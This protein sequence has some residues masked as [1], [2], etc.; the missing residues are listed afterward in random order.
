MK[1]LLP[2]ILI[3][4]FPYVLSGYTNPAYPELY[5]QDNPLYTITLDY[6]EFSIYTSNAATELMLNSRGLSI[7]YLV[8]DKDW[9][10][11]SGMNI[12][13]KFALGLGYKFT[14]KFKYLDYNWGLLWRPVR[15]LSI[16][17]V[18]KPQSDDYYT[19][20][21]IRP[22]RDY[23][24]LFGEIHT[25]N[26]KFDENPDY[27]TGLEI[28]PLDYL[29]VV[30]SYSDSL[31]FAG[32][33]RF[34]LNKFE[35]L[36]IGGENNHYE[37]F[38]RLSSKPFTP[39]IKRNRIYLLRLNNRIIERK[40]S[41]FDEGIPLYDLVEKINK[42]AANRNYSGILLDL[43]G[44]SASFSSAEELREALIDFKENGKKVYV[45]LPNGGNVNYWLASCA[46]SIFMPPGGSLYICGLRIESIHLKELLKKLGISA[47]FVSIGKYKS[48]AEMFT[49]DSMSESAREENRELLTDFY[50]QLRGG[51]ASARNLKPD[52]VS[53]LINDGIFSAKRAKDAGLIDSVAHISS[54]ASNLK[55][56]DVIVNPSRSFWSSRP[57]L[58]I[59]YASGTIAQQDGGSSIFGSGNIIGP[60]FIKTVNKVK[61]DKS[62]KGVLLRIDSPGG[63]ALQSEL[64]LNSLR[65]L[66]K[67][68]PVVISMGSIAASGGYYI[69]LIKNATVFA[70]S[71]TITGSIGVISGKFAFAEL[72]D[73]IGVNI[74]T[75]Q[76]GKSA[77]VFSLFDTLTD[78]NRAKLERGAEEF[79]KLFLDRVAEARNITKAEADSF[80]Q[81]RIYTGIKANEIGLVDT[82]GGL[83]SALD[84][85]EAKAKIK[86]G[87][88][89]LVKFPRV[90]SFMES[91]QELTNTGF[92]FLN[93]KALYLAPIVKV[94]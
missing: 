39:P 37:T 67:K 30:A 54:L 9:K 69:S 75:V 87:E 26:F 52:S 23:L 3:L 1:T 56:G 6:P 5:S 38:I 2:F 22:V 10:L 73:R 27:N 35:I 94:R 83:R 63:S 58:A 11:S 41:I 17:V 29:G 44:F 4:A 25:K 76:I 91:L 12:K 86:K 65:E 47:E 72:L 15:F 70:D 7:S 36:G 48:A 66:A 81:G 62:I 16:G 21:A 14:S 59:L 77:G 61:K 64:I 34:K 19:G 40:M 49:R 24:T 32:G 33:I 43:T 85:L 55:I 57:K 84:Y 90:K 50:K 20:L 31:G 60:S 92:P 53:A 68:K 42:L 74:D 78:E 89:K 88:Y 45:Y 8:K 13:N 28:K 18:G 79:Y 51:I 71:S 82:L 80:A 93:D 46:D